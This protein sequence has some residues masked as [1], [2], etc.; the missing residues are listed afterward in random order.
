MITLGPAASPSR[1]LEPAA[2]HHFGWNLMPAS[3]RMTSAFM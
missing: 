1:R 3:K 2:S